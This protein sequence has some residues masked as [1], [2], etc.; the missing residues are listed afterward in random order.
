MS[1]LGLGAMITL[2]GGN[3]DSVNAYTSSLGKK[4]VALKLDDDANS[5]DGALIMTFADDTQLKVYDEA[6]SCCESRYLSTDDDLTHYVN[7]KLKSIETLSADTIDNE[8]NYDVTEMTFIH[9]KT[10]KGTFVVNSYNNHNGYYGGIC[11]RC[12]SE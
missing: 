2:L 9:V 8:D 3:E 11:I 10:T 7:S 12:S 4:I 6:R 5:G 1:Q